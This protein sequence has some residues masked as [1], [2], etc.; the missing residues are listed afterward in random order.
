MVKWCTGV[1]RP[2]EPAL[3]DHD[4]AAADPDQRQEHQVRGLLPPGGQLVLVLL[5]LVL[6]VLVVLV[7][8]VLVIVMLVLVGLTLPQCNGESESSAWSCHATADLRLINQR[9]GS[10]FS[11]KITH[12]FYR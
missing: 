6:V 10:K 4:H 3:E 2:Q 7:L 5:L 1:T 8:V 12:L 9:D 11:R